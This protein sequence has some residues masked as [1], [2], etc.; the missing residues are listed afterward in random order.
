MKKQLRNWF[1]KD[2]RMTITKAQ[3]MPD[4]GYGVNSINVNLL[5][6]SPYAEKS[7]VL[8]NNE[9][10]SMSGTYG[11]SPFEIFNPFKTNSNIA[12][13]MMYQQG[14]LKDVSA[15]INKP[16]HDPILVTVSN[17]QVGYPYTVIYDNPIAAVLPYGAGGTR[18]NLDEGETVTWT[19]STGVTVIIK[20]DGDSDCKEFKITVK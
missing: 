7:I 19:S 4:G 11:L 15:E 5:T 2:S 16:G 14:L 1:Y 17:P 18:Y 3:S 8:N 12:W 9:S 20:R 10:T 6:F 13:L